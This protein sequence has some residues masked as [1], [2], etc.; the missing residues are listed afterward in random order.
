MNCWWTC[1]AMV[2]S[3]Y[4]RHCLRPED[5]SPVFARPWSRWSSSPFREEE[6]PDPGTIEAHT[7]GIPPLIAPHEWPETGLPSGGRYVDRLCELTG[8][9][10]LA[11]LEVPWSAAHLEALI[12]THGPLVFAW[13]V[14]GAR[15]IGHAVVLTGVSQEHDT[16]GYVDPN[17]GFAT[18][19]PRRDLNLRVA[20]LV[21][22]E[23]R[24]GRHW[25]PL[26][27]PARPPL[28]AVIYS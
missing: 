28:R 15:F 5:L 13:N 17:L 7:L 9:Q 14:G 26:Y 27:Y 22:R 23:V 20:P 1:L 6:Y 8:F 4:G 19:S 16:V 2:L 18:S 25:W 12:R 11:H 24:D 10:G 21:R 3:Y